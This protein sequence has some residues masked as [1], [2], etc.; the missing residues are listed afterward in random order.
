MA[1]G[2]WTIQNKELPG[3]YINFVGLPS[4]LASIGDR[5]VVAIARELDWGPVGEFIIIEDQN[6][7]RNKIGYNLT[8]SEAQF[9]EQ[10]LLGTNTTRGAQKVLIYRLGGSGQAQATATIGGLTVTAAQPGTRGN[11]ISIIISPVLDSA[12]TDDT[13]PDAPVEKYAMYDILVTLAGNPVATQT[14][15]EFVSEEDFTPATIEDLT[16]NSWVKYTGTGE[17]TATVGTTLLGGVNPTTTNAAYSDFLN[18]L[19]SHR[20]DI[21]IY[22]GTNAT[23]RNSFRAFA[24]RMTEEEGRHC[25]TV[26]QGFPGA[27]HECVISVDSTISLVLNDDSVLD[28]TNGGLAWWI[29]GAEAGCPIGVDLTYKTHP[30]AVELRGG[31]TTAELKSARAEGTLTMLDDDGVIRILDDINTFTSFTTTK[32]PVFSRNQTIRALWTFANSV[33]T[34]FNNYYIGNINNTEDGR[35]LFKAAVIKIIEQMSGAGA[36]QNFDAT[37]DIDVVVGD[38]EDGTAIYI[39]VYLQVAG[40]VTKIYMNVQVAGAVQVAV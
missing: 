4:T 35:N 33:Y 40:A 21:V 32:G 36:F 25:Q 12:Y 19:E 38:Q 34:T 22:D 10:I 30:L 20:F 17:L 1:G 7:I 37:T 39:W 28:S 11:D 16:D 8:D 9:L 6:Q 24:I 29:G 15:G 18:A 27:D 31:R 13:D 3:V 14:V 2:R 26:V 23:L 5:G